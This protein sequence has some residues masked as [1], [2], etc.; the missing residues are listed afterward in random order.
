MWV[1]KVEKD[2]GVLISD[3]TIQEKPHTNENEVLCRHYDHTKGRAVQG[4]NLLN[5]LYHVNGISIPV[6]FELIKKPVE[7]C[8]IKTHEQNEPV[9]IQKTN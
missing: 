3:D 2:D 8:D 9:F 1:R 7:Y 5:C 6:A 4:F